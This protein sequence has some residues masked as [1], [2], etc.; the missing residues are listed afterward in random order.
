[1]TRIPGHHFARNL[2]ARR[3][4]IWQ[5][6]RRDFR[7]RYVGS[8]AG[9]LW[10]VFHPI[11][12]LALWVFVFQICIKIPLPPDSVTQNYALYL[13][14]G[15]LPWMLFQDT[16]LRSTSG[17][18]DHAN[19]I[20]K[21][22]FPSEVVAVSLF[23]SSLIHHLIGVALAITAVAAVEHKFSPLVL[24]LPVYMLF[25]GFLGVGV[26]WVASSL[27]VYLRD[28]GQMLNVILQI[29]YWL[30]P[31]F[32][33]EDMIPANYRFL[34]LWNVR[35]YRDRLLSGN[36]PQFQELGI[37]AIYSTVV[38]IAGGLFFRHLKRGFADVL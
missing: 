2:V 25:V 10:G 12:Q 23:L 16:V 8:A 34:I 36:W 6:V 3:A 30:T 7:Q 28:T 37:L 33:S 29:W 27:H 35:A 18:V 9:W 13:L 11:V 14:A 20:T 24:V 32:I 31:I 17:L 22:A 38:F 4:L 15:Y 26:G 1:V 21:T 19:L 5:L